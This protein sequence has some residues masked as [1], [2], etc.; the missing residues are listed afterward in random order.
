MIY[1]I[2][3]GEFV[4]I[5]VAN[6]PWARMHDFQVASPTKLELL[7]VS[8][9]DYEDEAR[10]H[11]EFLY[12]R[13][14]GEWFAYDELIA[15]TVA[16]IK[17]YYPDYQAPSIL[18]KKHKRIHPRTNISPADAVRVVV[19]TAVAM[20]EH[21]PVIDVRSIEHPE[22]GPGV[23]IWIPGYVSNGETIVDA[24]SMPEVAQS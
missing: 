13:K 15:V 19:N 5:G 22:H 12:C 16:N 17:S 1:F 6:N 14:K 24:S 23:L 7:A 11:A 2:R 18:K 3:N 21:E 20:M 9:G 4:K 8:P 10:Y